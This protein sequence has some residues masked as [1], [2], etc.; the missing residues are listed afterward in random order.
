V[1]G[2]REQLRAALSGLERSLAW[3]RVGI[4]LALLLSPSR[5]LRLWL[6]AEAS[7]SSRVLARAVGLRDASLGRTL[8]LAASRE[9]PRRHLYGGASVVD[10]F[11]G[12][13]A[14]AAVGNGRKRTIAVAAG[15]GLMGMLNALL[16]T[17]GQ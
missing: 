6:G 2:R 16:A 4:G 9:Q 8:A 14:L 11:D 3:A 15:A 12:A 5:S 10:L 1:R 7:P 17:R 13:V